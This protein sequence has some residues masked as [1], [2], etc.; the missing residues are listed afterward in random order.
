MRA[1]V[2]ATPCRAMPS[3]RAASQAASLRPSRSS[4]LRPAI[5][6]SY[7]ATCRACPGSSAQTSRSRNRRRPEAPSC[8]SRS[9]C[10]V[11]HAIATRAAISAWLRGAAPSSRNTRRSAG[12]SGGVPVPISIAPAAVSNRAAT[13]Q[14]PVAASSRRAKS[15]F[16]APRSPRPGESSEIASSRLV[17]PDPFG[18][19]N[20]FTRASGTQVR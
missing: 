20:T 2:T 10:G 9:I 12:P 17:L 6:A 5:A 8:N 16:R 19:N 7:E 15:A 3:S 18:P 13:P 4:R 11:S 1:A 14:R